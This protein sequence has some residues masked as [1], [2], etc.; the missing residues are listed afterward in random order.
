MRGFLPIAPR[1][2]TRYFQIQWGTIPSHTV[3]LG[4]CPISNMTA[5]RSSEESMLSPFVVESSAN[6]VE[7]GDVAV[8]VTH[9]LVANCERDIPGYF[10]F[11]VSS[12]NSSDS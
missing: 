4:S 3:A 7:L 5:P 6:D 1:Q 9:S 2:T 8:S 10:S 11:G 12:L